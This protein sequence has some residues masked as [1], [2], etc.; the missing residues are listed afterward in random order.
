MQ[1]DNFISQND[2]HLKAIELFAGI[3]GFHLGLS[4]AN[5]PVIWAND[6]DSLA[7]QVYRSNFG[8]HAIQQ[9]DIREINIKDIPDHDL[10][11]AG[12]PCQ[13]FSPAGKKQGVRDSLRGTL[14]ENIIDIIASK[15]PRYFLLENVKRLLTMEN[16][17]HFRVI[18]TALARLNYF[19]E[20]RV[21][22][23]R[24]FGIPQNRDRVFIIGTRIN[25]DHSWKFSDYSIFLTASDLNFLS[26]EY[27]YFNKN[28]AKY[29]L[30]IQQIKTK[31]QVWGFAYQHKMFTANLPVLPNIYPPKKI[32]DILQR[33]SEVDAQFDF[34]ADTLE[35]IK[36]STKVER[37]YNDVEIIY[38]QAGGARLGYTIF[39]VNGVAST[40]TASSSRHYER[41]QIGDRF[42]RLTNVEYARLMGFPDDW[43][44]VAKIY[45]QYSLYGNAVVPT[46]ITWIC[47]KINQLNYSN[48]NHQLVNLALK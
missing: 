10:L 25:L 7:C 12:F 1:K 4:S 40:L 36:K 22:S 8:D 47:Q 31:N 26:T 14:F 42:R 5:I 44:R 45:D 28:S 39:G 13:P 19:I 46:C 41:Y 32:R 17:T 20:W 48:A 9:A 16:G 21:L 2:H 11:T 3:G 38:N 27:Q 29:L 15:Q 37:Y 18:L 23:P 33:P 24:S 34:T 35:R 30:P 43:C 6:V